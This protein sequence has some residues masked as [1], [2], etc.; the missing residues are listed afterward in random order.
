MVY[1]S[2]K[3]SYITRLAPFLAKKKRLAADSW[4][5]DTSSVQPV[6]DPIQEWVSKEA[7]HIAH[8]YPPTWRVNKHGKSQR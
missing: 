7:P 8:R 2:P 3:S 5:V 6:F 4:G 1:A